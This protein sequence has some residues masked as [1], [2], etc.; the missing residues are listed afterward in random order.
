[1]LCLSWTRD[2][3]LLRLEARC[4]AA[5]AVLAVLGARALLAGSFALAVLRGAASARVGA[6]V[7]GAGARLASAR[8]VATSSVLTR[9]GHVVDW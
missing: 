5:V 6:A 8:T 4:L 2:D 9:A 1:M 3:V 7:A